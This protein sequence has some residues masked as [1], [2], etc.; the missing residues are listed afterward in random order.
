[1]KLT[2]VNLLRCPNCGSKL[3]CIPYKVINE[4][5]VLDGVLKCQCGDAHIVY[6]GVPKM[7]TSSSLPEGFIRN[8]RD[9][10]LQ[11][12]PV[13][14]SAETTTSDT[15]SFSYQWSTHAYDDLTWELYLPERIEIFY[16]Y[17]NM[18]PEQAG[19]VRLLDAGCG[20][21]TLSAQLAA[22]GFEVVGMDYS[23]S[24]YRAYQYKLFES[25]VTNAVFDRLHFVQGDVQ[26][27]PF[28]Q[29]LFD[30][31]Y[32]DGVL[33]H[34]PDTKSSFMALA[35]VVKPGGR[36]LV[37]L[38]RRDT[39]P[40]VTAKNSL[41]KLVRR[42]TTNLSYQNKMRVCYTGAA[43]LL[44]GVRVG[45]LLGYKK[46]RLIPLRLK[47]TNLFDTISPQFNHEHTPDEV[48]SWFREAGYTDIKDV[49]LSEYR[50][51]E[52]GF[53]MIGT[54]GK[55]GDSKEEAVF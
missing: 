4:A 39:K 53:A 17:F 28:E 34:T 21:G 6:Q 22:E 49:S 37:W 42:S 12:A 27:P 20:N 55:L 45:Q 54:R 23:E 7:V 1:M 15:F 2:L 3:T 10:L 26:H 14:A 48:A 50:L 24:V 51:D 13:L 44:L 19:G 29:G 38:Y 9:R 35:P 11:D 47:A 43:L 41:V 18:T 46:R 36:L 52:G 25:Q 30:L 5:E 40:R 31:V 8:Y 32:S 33:H 16:R